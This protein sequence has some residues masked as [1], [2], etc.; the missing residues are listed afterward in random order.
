[1]STLFPTKLLV[2]YVLSM[3]TPVKSR[4]I[5]ARLCEKS[6][7]YSLGDILRTLRRKYGYGGLLKGNAILFGWALVLTAFS[8]LILRKIPALQ[9][10]LSAVICF[11]MCHIAEDDLPRAFLITAFILSNC[12]IGGSWILTEL[13]VILFEHIGLEERSQ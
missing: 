11:F 8:D 10:G 1:M 7:T 9:T 2:H 12:F 5:A 3:F 13:F 6:D 4:E